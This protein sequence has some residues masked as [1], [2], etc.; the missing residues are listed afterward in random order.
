MNRQEQRKGNIKLYTHIH[1][2]I[3]SKALYFHFIHWLYNCALKVLVVQSWNWFFLFPVPGYSTRETVY[4]H[5]R[6]RLH[7]NL[8]QN[9]RDTIFWK[10]KTS[11]KDDSGQSLWRAVLG[12]RVWV[13]LC[14]FWLY[15][16]LWDLSNKANRIRLCYR[17]V[18]WYGFP[19]G[20]CFCFCLF[21]TRNWIL[22]CVRSCIIS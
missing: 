13:P 2:L 5:R 1:L 11:W 16:I 3:T 9:S 15:W 4:R 18:L 6:Q 10:I 22:V 21:R 8:Q 19:V 12:K 14:L 20:F 7:L 17:A